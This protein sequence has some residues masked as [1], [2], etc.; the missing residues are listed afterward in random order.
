MSIER[1]SSYFNRSRVAVVTYQLL[2][3]VVPDVV[4][5]VLAVLEPKSLRY[6]LV[7][8]AVAIQLRRRRIAFVVR[9]MNHGFLWS[10]TP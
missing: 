5:H 4:P 2:Q 8:G 10:L 9:V 3:V 6:T 7:I 1:A